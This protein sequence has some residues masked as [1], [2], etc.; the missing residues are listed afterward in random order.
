M[1]GVE[2]ILAWDR[3]GNGFIVDVPN[4]AQKNPPCEYAWTLKIS[5]IMNHEVGF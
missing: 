4:S 1:L 5:K 3:V 2:G